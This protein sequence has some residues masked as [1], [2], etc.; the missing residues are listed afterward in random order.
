VTNTAKALYT[1]WNSFGI[2]AY[3]EE[4]IPDDA[5]LPYITY[6][7]VDPD[8]QE[9]ASIQGRVWYRSD[10]F[11]TLNAKVD[12]ISNRIGDGHSIRTNN[13][14]VVLYKDINFAQIQPFPEDTLMRV[15]YINLII[16]SYTN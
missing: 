16:N 5:Q 9:N 11:T 6:T 7:M 8:W 15:A 13:G 10:N 12:E 3:L 14:V 4:H 1:F 2:P